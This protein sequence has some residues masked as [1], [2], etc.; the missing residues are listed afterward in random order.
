MKEQ[1]KKENRTSALLRG[2]LRTPDLGEYLESYT[3]EMGTLS[4][5]IYITEICKTTG[6]IPEQVIKCAGIERTYGHQLFNGTRK[7]SRDKVIQLAFGFH[8]D[9]DGTQKLLQ[10]AQ[11]NP[12]YPKIKRDAAI[13]HCISHR[14]EILET[15][16]ILQ[17]LGLTL[18]GEG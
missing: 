11:K 6:Q 10:V 14:K 8:L 18:L 2:L 9:L 3:A 1:K 15:Q 17:A 7:P 5:N 16:S 12:L 13:V 4:F